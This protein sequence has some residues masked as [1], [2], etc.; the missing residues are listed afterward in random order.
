M[1]LAANDF[2][3]LI[4]SIVSID[5]DANAVDSVISSSVISEIIGTMQH[6]SHKFKVHGSFW[7]NLISI[8]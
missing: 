6:E 4:S 5:S 1:K 8:T 2:S 3:K 7:Q